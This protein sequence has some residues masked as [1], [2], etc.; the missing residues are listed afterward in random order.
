MSLLKRRDCSIITWWREG[1]V[2]L[3]PG[4]EKG[5]FYYHLVERRDCSIIT[6]WREG[7]VLLSPGGE[8]GLFCR[9]IEDQDEAHGAPEECSGETP[10]S[11][12]ACSGKKGIILRAIC[13][14][15][16]WFSFHI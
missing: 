6:W 14:T 13:I 1:T 4:G 3:S 2:L 16:R 12:L 15:E 7:T 5:L 10:E 11:L 9:H 8:K